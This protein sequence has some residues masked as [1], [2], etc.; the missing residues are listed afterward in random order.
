M[1][2]IWL[3]AIVMGVALLLNLPS[4]ALFADYG[5]RALVYGAL[6]AFM[7]YFGV[8][9]PEGELSPAHTAGIVAALSVPHEAH[10]LM[11]WAIFLGG[12]IGGT[13]LVLR[14]QDTNL[15]RRLTTRTAS[16]V[17]AIS[18]RVTLSFLVAAQAFYLLGGQMPIRV[19]IH[20]ELELM[21]F[22]LFYSLVY[23]LIFML[24]TYSDG[25]SV[26]RILGDGWLVVA[27]IMLLP[28]PFGVLAAIVIVITPNSLLVFIVGS[29]LVTL[30]IHGLSRAQYQLRK[31]LDELRSL[32]AVGQALQ[33]DLKLS[34]LLLAVYKQVTDLLQVDQFVVALYE[35]TTGKI[36]FPLAL[37]HSQP[38]PDYRDTGGE[39]SLLNH[40]LQTRA[41]LLVSHDVAQTAAQIGLQSPG[42]KVQSWL[43]V[44]LLAGG[45]L[46]GA[47]VVTSDDQ[48]QHFG[49]DDLRLLNIVAASASI[50]IDNAQLYEQ[51]TAR[52][53]QLTTL[54][55]VVALLTGTLSPEV[56]LDAVLSSA[57][58]VSEATAAA[59]YLF[60]DEAQQ[61]LA[62]V[63]SAGLSSHFTTDPP[64]PLLT[65]PH[66]PPIF[67]S[68]VLKDERALP[69]RP[70]MGGEGKAAWAELPLAVGDTRL[71]TILFY[72]DQP[73]AFSDDQV[74]ILKAFT[75]QATQAIKNAQLYTTTDKALERR[76]EQM[77][78]LA[79]LGR[80]LTATMN[81]TSICNLVLARAL[82][83]TR[84]SSGFIALQDEGELTIAAHAGYPP[85]TVSPAAVKVSLTGTVLEIGAAVRSNDL[86]AEQTAPPLLKS[87]RSQLS[88]PIMRS[89]R[90][91]GVITLESDSPGT[92]SEED[93]TFVTQLASQTI[94]AIDNTRLFERIAEARDRLQVIL[95]AMTEAIVLVDK[96]GIIALANPRV[97][98]INLN[99]TDLLN[100]DVDKLL[101][102]PA[103]DL[104]ER[105]GFQSD[106][107]VRKL[108]KELRTPGEWV[109][110]EPASYT[111]DGEHGLIYIKRE[112]IPVRGEESE[113]L[114]MLLVFYDETEERELTQMRDDLSNMI[115]HDLRSPLTAVTTGLKL[116]R[117]LVPADSTFH[118]L[119][120]TTTETSQRAIRKLMSRVD[121]LL[122]ISKMESGQLNLETEPT[123]LAT[124]AD[125]VCM[126][127]SPLAHEL[128]VT[129]TSQIDDDAP[130]FDID[131]DKVERIL[132]NLVDN[133]LKFC[134]SNGSVTIRSHKTGMDG[135]ADGFAR[136][137]VVDTG[138]G[139]PEDYK[140]RLFERFVQVKGRRGAR[141]GIGLG[142]T[143]CRL[144]TEA[145]GGKI[146]IEDNPA[147]GSIF[148]FTLPVMKLDKPADT[149]EFPKMLPG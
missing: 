21:I 44:P 51:Q 20:D 113:P 120:Q 102:R 63:R 112:V 143:F 65:D 25:R 28:F 92:F 93:A 49:P 115:V 103:L 80:Q 33:A 132:Q 53:N 114:G 108:L 129:V 111:V 94:I 34:P 126:E 36:Q 57:S 56:V 66:Q 133:A 122:D 85:M 84:V 6:T 141:R 15:R 19:P 23:F 72:Y 14:T 37:R 99:P 39:K 43:G 35:R 8:L 128:E 64:T 110:T 22:G 16:S 24:E 60:W 7:L 142:L 140:N 78:T 46:L 123:E 2:I 149:G 139:V 88:I 74:E 135:A 89:G 55:R 4:G 50:A 62:L 32:A 47:I 40:L 117:D 121:S 82:E 95:N 130:L 104:A 45:K 10:P 38:I 96:N 26:G 61:T 3:L 136:I 90:I 91:L 107:K 5:G 127:L 29:I 106:Q 9:L 101:E 30:G 76:A 124:L 77:Y 54:N 11:L 69:Y 73:Q 71:G 109:G 138:P 125:S 81:L 79:T 118:A 68:D 17:V 48:R 105:M 134:P 137:D 83:L 86:R 119:V 59:V 148:A 100:Q 12:V 70:I 131:A 58:V 146:W 116:L 98:L 75:N 13:L 1:L 31:Q 41:A 145:H 67:I 52:A 42:E 147:G 144:V 18:A 87:T 27:G 97:D